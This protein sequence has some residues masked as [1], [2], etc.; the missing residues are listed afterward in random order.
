MDRLAPAGYLSRLGLLH[1]GH[2]E[3][4]VSLMSDHE[5][6]LDQTSRRGKRYTQRMTDSFEA[7]PSFQRSKNA[8]RGVVN[9]PQAEVQRI[10]N[11]AKSP[12][13]EKTAKIE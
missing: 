12:A 3:L 5:H 6:P 11:A 7:T 10:S 9:L 8:I 1:L 13:T 4:L 2:K